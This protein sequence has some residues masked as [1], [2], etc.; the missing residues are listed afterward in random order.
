MSSKA[1]LELASGTARF[2]Y[3]RLAAAAQWATKLWGQLASKWRRW[4]PSCERSPADDPLA[5]CPSPSSLAQHAASS[6]RRYSTVRSTYVNAL[7]GAHRACPKGT[8]LAVSAAEPYPLQTIAYP[9]LRHCPPP[10]PLL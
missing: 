10:H 5:K 3:H 8:A 2:G 1:L 9:T 7:T 6:K 4:A